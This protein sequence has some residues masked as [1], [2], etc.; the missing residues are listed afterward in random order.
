MLRKIEKW[1]VQLTFSVKLAN[2]FKN[3]SWKKK[4]ESNIV[5][6]QMYCHRECTF[7]RLEIEELRKNGIPM[8]PNTN[9]IHAHSA[10]CQFHEANDLKRVCKCSPQAWSFAILNTTAK[11]CN[12]F[13]TANVRFI[14]FQV[15]YRSVHMNPTLGRWLSAEYKHTTYA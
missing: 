8:F 2:S 13:L 7:R 5:S 11:K 3:K 1:H 6:K 10:L 14:D 9:I 12:S 4:N 15:I